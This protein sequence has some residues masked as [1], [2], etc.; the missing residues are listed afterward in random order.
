[1]FCSKHS[2]TFE[3]TPDLCVSLCGNASILW[4]LYLGPNV[5]PQSEKDLIYPLPLACVRKS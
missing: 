4:V 3:N 2:I 1:M 5:T